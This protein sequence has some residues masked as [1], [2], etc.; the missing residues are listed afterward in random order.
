VRGCLAGPVVASTGVMSDH[1]LRGGDGVTGQSTKKVNEAICDEVSEREVNERLNATRET[2]CE[3]RGRG[4]R[5]AG[6]MGGL[7]SRAPGWM[8]GPRRSA[9]TKI[10]L[11]GNADIMRTIRGARPESFFGVG[12]VTCARGARRHGGRREARRHPCGFS[13]G[14]RTR[15]VG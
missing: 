8:K 14:C 3:T 6:P 10:E 11:I 5:F 15:H 4:R 1:L 9:G 2:M 12:G 13:G 7:G